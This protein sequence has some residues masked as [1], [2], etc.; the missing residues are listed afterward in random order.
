MF[1]LHA[2][3]AQ[4]GDSIILEFGPKNKPR[5][6]LI[7]GGPPDVFD[8]DLNEALDAIVGKGGK[9]DLLLLSHIDND[10]VV[11][12]LDLLAALQADGANGLPPR[13]VA[14]K[15]WHNSFA[16]TVDTD[17]QIVQRLQT[18]MSLASAASVAM[19]FADTALLGLVEGQRLRTLAKQLKIKIN[20]G[21]TDGLVLVDT[22]KQPIK[23]G[24]LSLQVVGPNKASLAELRKKWLEWLEKTEN[25]AMNDPTVLANADQSVPNLSSIV[26]LATCNGKTALLTGDARGDHLISGLE[27]AKLLT[28]GKL[29]V[30][31]L[32]VQHHGSN[33]NATKTF[34]KNITADKY[35]ISAN[36]ENDNPDLETLEW[37]VETAHAAG[38]PIEIIVT[39]STSSTKKIKQTHKPSQFGYTLTT[40][41]EADHSIA[42]AL[43]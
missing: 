2:V 28:N 10:H 40:R 35:L 4:F 12:L 36:G 18:L 23:F 42:V 11:G 34:F 38:R 27:T 24:P 13:V 8:D 33:R 32:K 21:F 17:G 25:D 14:R 5:Y 6:M 1:V 29:H 15:L 7:D 30:D 20:P 16:N 9:L 19:P 43:A 37:I 41:P 31:L 3:Q 26:V 22:A 39:N